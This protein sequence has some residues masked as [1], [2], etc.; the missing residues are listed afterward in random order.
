MNVLVSNVVFAWLASF[1]LAGMATAQTLHAVVVADRSPSAGWGKFAPNITID[2]LTIFSTLHNHVPES[3][4]N[5]RAVEIEEDQYSSPALI[6]ELI[7]EVDPAPG[8]T[9][10]FYYTGHGASDDR[11]HY[12]DL[13]QGKLYRDD[14]RRAI[15][16]RGAQFNCL[17]TDCCNMRSDGELFFAPAP[18][19]EPPQRISALFRS[20]FFSADGW[21][22]INGSSPGEGAFFTADIDNDIPGSLFTKELSAFFDRYRNQATTWDHLIREVSLG[23]SVAFKTQYPKGASVAKGSPV[24]MQ[25]NIDAIAYPGKPERSG[26]RSGLTVRDHNGRGALITIVSPGFPGERVYDLQTGEYISMRPQQVIVAVNGHPINQA[27]AFAEAVKLSPQVMR[28]K[29]QDGNRTRDVLMRLR[30]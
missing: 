15:E 9:L 29:I 26:P 12:L 22:D 2:A 14:L 7:S 8:D 17:V 16:Q 23:V 25:Q 21:V 27:R 20:L 3:Q 5:Y 4:L 28:V 6:L 11:G 1:V 19:I 13:A 24:Q 10:V 18:M 30:Y